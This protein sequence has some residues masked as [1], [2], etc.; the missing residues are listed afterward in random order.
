MAERPSPTW[1]CRRWKDG[2]TWVARLRGGSDMAELND[3]RGIGP[4]TA[5]ALAAHGLDSVKKLA[6]AGI[7]AIA[8]V[9]GFGPIR[10]ERVRAEARATVPDD[11]EPSKKSAKKSK[12]KATK[13]KKSDE[14]KKSKGKK[15]KGKA[16]K[17]KAKKSKKAKAKKKS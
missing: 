17:S 3:I 9:P 11:D 2:A 12:A 8:A 14:A 13:P 7:D 1:L 4:A 6:K 5:A 15:S 10:A 16:K